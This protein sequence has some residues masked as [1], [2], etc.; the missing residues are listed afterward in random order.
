MTATH[1]SL[2]I[3]F[4]PAVYREIGRKRSTQA[5]RL[6][7]ASAFAVAL[8][9]SALY[10]QV[11]YRGAQRELA[12]VEKQ[13]LDAAAINHEVARLQAKL[14]AAEFDA[15]LLTYLRHPWPRRR[16]LQALVTPLPETVSLS[17]LS[18]AREAL[19]RVAPSGERSAEPGATTE[20]KL[21]PSVADL[22]KLRGA[23]AGFRT[24]V[25]L[26]GHASDPAALH[27][28]LAELGREKLFTKVELG[29]IAQANNAQGGSRF[30]LR[31]V[32][33]PGVGQAEESRT[34]V[35]PGKTDV[36]SVTQEFAEGARR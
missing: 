33:H 21:P 11:I 19:A 36:Q 22:K 5:L 12:A 30:S 18:I 8:A 32:L 3:D 16:V 1:S 27:Q 29:S 10:Q 23:A 26:S 2:D 24:V 15:E 25:T 13:Y 28:Y 6:L 35:Q 4:L 17:E 14:Q 7:V 31:V 34:E 20:V 9:A